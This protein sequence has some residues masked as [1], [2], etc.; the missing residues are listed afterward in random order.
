M[1]LH[2]WYDDGFVSGAIGVKDIAWEEISPPLPSEQQ[3]YGLIYVTVTLPNGQDYSARYDEAR[4]T[5]T[6]N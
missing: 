5:N 3:E 6:S 1:V 2:N 4:L